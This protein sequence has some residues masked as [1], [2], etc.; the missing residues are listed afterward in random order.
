MKFIF[1]AKTKN[2]E[3]KE[4]VI[5]AA[6]S[7]AA[8]AVLQKNDLFP[9][10]IANEEADKSVI[11]TIL[12]YYDRV[13]DRELVIFFR[14]LAILIEARISIIIALTAILEQTSN[15]FF[16]KV[17]KETIADIENG[18]PFS[19]ALGKHRDVFSVLVVNVIRA[20]ETSGNLK[21]SIEYIAENIEKNYTLASRVRS[22]MIYPSIILVVFFLIGFIMVS[23]ILPK[24]TAIIKELNAYIPWYTKIIIKVGDF[25]SVYWWAVLIIILGFIGGVL[26]YVRTAQGKR[27][28][29]QMK[30]KLPVFGIIFRGIYIARFAQNLKVL[31]SGGIP[32]IRALNITS[33]VI[34]N[35]VYETLLKK[36]ADEVKVGGNISNAFSKSLLIPPVVSHMMKIG[37]DSGQIE[38]VLTHIGNFYE[39]E[40]DMT[41]K[42]LSTLIE[43]VLMII[44]GIGVGFMAFAILMP[45]YNIAGQIK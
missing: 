45:I 30:I 4:G 37:E 38:Q 22:A 27:E 11:K 1:K 28:W 36:A 35:T 39:Q 5:E 14:Q 40:T 13:T 44:I 23:F 21:K 34:N 16:V 25:M 24:L 18:L 31:L 10:S 29:D 33:T 7:D 42:N 3:L 6:N 12:K 32:I 19:D 41:T 2:G 15:K 26:Y 20:G 43:P 9:I 8:I 17:L